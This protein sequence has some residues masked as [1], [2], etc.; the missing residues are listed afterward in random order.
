MPPGDVLVNLLSSSAPLSI[1]LDSNM[2]DI[3]PKA[4]ACYLGHRPRVRWQAWVKAAAR[5]PPHLFKSLQSLY[6]IFFFLVSVGCG[7]SQMLLMTL[8]P[9]F[10]SSTYRLKSWL[11][12]SPFYGDFSKRDRWKLEIDARESE[13][14]MLMTDHVALIVV[15]LSDS[16]SRAGSPVTIK[17]MIR[18]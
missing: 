8:S 3:T 16:W 11:S 1:S 4:L 2:Y 5:N 10:K 6:L 13:R 7:G 12:G 9:C 14:V 18:K 17:A 15:P